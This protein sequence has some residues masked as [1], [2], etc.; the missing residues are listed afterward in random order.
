MDAHSPF[1]SRLHT[2]TTPSLSL[3]LY[4]HYFFLRTFLTTFTIYLMLSPDVTKM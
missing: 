3:D 1:S 2:T 4:F